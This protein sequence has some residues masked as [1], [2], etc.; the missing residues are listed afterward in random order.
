MKR[1][2]VVSFNWKTK[3]ILYTDFE[4]KDSGRKAV[5]WADP[6]NFLWKDFPKS[7]GWAHF[8]YCNKEAAKELGEQRMKYLL[9]IKD[10]T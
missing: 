5:G 7:E 1:A 9:G 4:G 10:Q 2:V 3:E 8:H 6:K